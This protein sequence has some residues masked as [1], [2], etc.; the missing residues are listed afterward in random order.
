MTVIMGQADTGRPSVEILNCGHPA[1]LL[2]RDGIAALV[3]DPDPG[4]ASSCD[5]LGCTPRR[6]LRVGKRDRS[7]GEVLVLDVDDDQSVR[8]G[9]R[10]YDRSGLPA[11]FRT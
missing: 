6:V 2:L 5:R 10:F 7:P 9:C 11:C 1:P 4:G 3:E 8:H